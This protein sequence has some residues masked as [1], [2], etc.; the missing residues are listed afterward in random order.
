[1]QFQYDFHR[2]VNFE[3]FLVD[4]VYVCKVEMDAKILTHRSLKNFV[5][6]NSTKVRFFQLLYLPLLRSEAARLSELESSKEV[7]KNV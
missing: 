6:H 3:V 4:C 2:C 1:M 7:K 5:L